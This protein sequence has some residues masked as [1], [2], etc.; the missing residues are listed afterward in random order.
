[1]APGVWREWRRDAET[2]EILGRGAKTFLVTMNRLRPVGG[3]QG[4]VLMGHTA[5]GLAR[6]PAGANA[7][8]SSLSATMEHKCQGKSMTW[9]FKGR[10]R[11]PPRLD[12][13]GLTRFGPRI[14]TAQFGLSSMAFNEVDRWKFIVMIASTWPPSS[15]LNSQGNAGDRWIRVKLP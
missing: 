7:T 1:M 5:W 11:R 6:E 8:S 10:Y 9:T 4:R 13:D 12:R 14:N 3:C 15:I 2:N